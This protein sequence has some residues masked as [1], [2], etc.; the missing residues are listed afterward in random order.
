MAKKY[1]LYD[2]GEFTI[3][4]L[5][6]GYREITGLDNDSDFSDKEL[7]NYLLEALKEEGDEKYMTTYQRRK[8][9]VRNEAIEWQLDFCNHN[10][11]YEELQ[12]IQTKFEKL[13]K[14]YGLLEEFRENG[15]I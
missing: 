2:L 13:G 11:S 10:Y 9:K 5:R 6:E 15:I 4:E 14:R 1:K 7:Y 12:K 8:E 3:E